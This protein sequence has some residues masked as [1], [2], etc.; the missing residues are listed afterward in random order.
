MRANPRVAEDAGKVA[1]TRGPLVYCLEEIDN[2]KRLHL[3]RAGGARGGID[4]R[5][6][7]GTLGGIVALETDGLR[8]S[9]AWEGPLYAACAAPETH[10]VR[11]RFIPYYAWANR[12]VGEMRVWIRE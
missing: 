9:E 1:L 8:E 12:G 5:W 3:L 11:L 6:E 2:G 10:P 7:P 4:A